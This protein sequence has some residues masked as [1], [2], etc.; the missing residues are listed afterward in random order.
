MAL[1]P[2]MGYKIKATV[3][4]VKENVAQAIELARASI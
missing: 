1:D 4:D 3:T 2:G